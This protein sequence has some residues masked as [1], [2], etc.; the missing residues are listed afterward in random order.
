VP[1]RADVATCTS[2]G[3]AEPQVDV[4]FSDG[5]VYSLP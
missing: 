2:E 4:V 5:T 3:T 1:R